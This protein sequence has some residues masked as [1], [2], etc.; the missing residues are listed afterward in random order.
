MKKKKSL[1]RKIVGI[2]IIMGLVSLLITYANVSALK[3]ISQFNNDIS[4]AFTN[5]EE[6]VK[7]SDEKA[8]EQSKADAAKYAKSSEREVP[9]VPQTESEA[10]AEVEK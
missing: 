6:A 10:E 1:N 5:Y 9:E 8:I 3:L 2:L 4:T 7:L